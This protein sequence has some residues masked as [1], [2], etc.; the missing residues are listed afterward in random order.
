MP[1]WVPA[2][3]AVVTV[4]MPSISDRL[5]NGIG[6]GSQRIGAGG[7]STSMQGAVR[8]TP[9]SCASWARD[10]LHARRASTCCARALASALWAANLSTGEKRMMT[11]LIVGCD[12]QGAVYEGRLGLAGIKAEYAQLTNPDRERG[13]ADDV[14]RGATAPLRRRPS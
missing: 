7:I 5:S 10:T 3:P 1:D 4:L 13:S 8:H 14:L 11:P 12:R 6:S 2:S 9:A